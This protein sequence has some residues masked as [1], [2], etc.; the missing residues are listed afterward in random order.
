MNMKNVMQYDFEKT[1]KPVTIEELQDEVEKLQDDLRRLE[2]QVA[3]LSNT[4]IGTIVKNVEAVDSPHPATGKC[5]RCKSCMNMR[6]P[7]RSNPHYTCELRHST[8]EP[9]WTC[10]LYK[11]KNNQRIAEPVSYCEH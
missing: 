8:I 5:Q 9:A 10:G 11:D 7:H 1:G 2:I 4:D 6:M 3:G